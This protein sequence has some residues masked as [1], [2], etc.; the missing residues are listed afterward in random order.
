MDGCDPS[1]GV[2]ISSGDQMDE[3]VQVN[4]N[5]SMFSQVWME[6]KQTE[7]QKLSLNLLW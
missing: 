6:E 5:Y 7:H 1:L 2:S 4:C 3:T